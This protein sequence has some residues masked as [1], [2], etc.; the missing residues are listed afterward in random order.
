MTLVKTKSSC[1][2]FLRDFIKSVFFASCVTIIIGI[3]LFVNL[4]SGICNIVSIEIPSS[5][6]FE[7][8]LA[9]T[10]D[11]SLAIILK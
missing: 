10:P 9:N 6:K 7:V 8:I 1:S 2:I 5:F 4:L 11:I 3:A